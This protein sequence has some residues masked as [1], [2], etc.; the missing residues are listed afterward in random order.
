MSVEC[1]LHSLKEEDLDMLT[2]LGKSSASPH[3]KRRRVT[4]CN[5]VSTLFVRVSMAL[6]ISA[7]RRAHKAG[8]SPPLRKTCE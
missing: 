8:L 5:S 7:V 4:F 1:L 2:V 6:L 3:Q